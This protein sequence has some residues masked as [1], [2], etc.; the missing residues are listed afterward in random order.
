MDTEAIIQPFLLL[1]TFTFSVFSIQIILLWSPLYTYPFLVVFSV[2]YI[3]ISENNWVKGH[4]HL[5]DRLYA[6]NIMVMYIPII[7]WVLPFLCILN[8]SLYN[9]YS[10]LLLQTGGHRRLSLFSSIAARICSS[11]LGSL[12]L[13]WGFIS[14]IFSQYFYSFSFILKP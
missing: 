6:K 7:S 12:S 3:L 13:S 8:S 1:C 10:I 11:C 9:Q 2:G 5:K 14:F 4:V